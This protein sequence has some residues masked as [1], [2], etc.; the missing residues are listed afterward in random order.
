MFLTCQGFVLEHP[1]PLHITINGT[2]YVKLCNKVPLETMVTARIWHLSPPAQCSAPISIICRACCRFKARK[3]YG[4]FFRSGIIRSNF[5]CS[6]KTGSLGVA[7]PYLQIPATGLPV[8]HYA[9]CILIYDRCVNFGDDYNK[10]ET[11]ARMLKHISC[12]PFYA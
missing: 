9:N 10:Y 6:G 11:H 5:Q 4:L 2:Y 12:N 7:N 1:I 8:H 3:G